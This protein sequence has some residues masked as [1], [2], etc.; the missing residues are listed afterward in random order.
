MERSRQPCSGEVEIDD[1]QV[2]PKEVRGGPPAGRSRSYTSPAFPALARKVD[3]RASPH[4]ID[5]HGT[6]VP[7]GP[8]LTRFRGDAFV[9]AQSGI[10]SLE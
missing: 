5:R 2:T 8:P 3:S 6:R 7:R 9:P 4:F 10:K 1:R